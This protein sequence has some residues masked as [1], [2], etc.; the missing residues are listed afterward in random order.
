MAF[1]CMENSMFQIMM[2]HSFSQLCF[3]SIKGILVFTVPCSMVI[4]SF[5]VMY[6]HFVIYLDKTLI[7]DKLYFMVTLFYSAMFH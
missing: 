7:D 5:D 2:A 3:K 1:Q 6:V 4:L